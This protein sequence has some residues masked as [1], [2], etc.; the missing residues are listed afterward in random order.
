MKPDFPSCEVGKDILLLGRA[1]IGEPA[2]E[3][4]TRSIA[5]HTH[6]H[7]HGCY[8]L[9]TQE[10]PSIRPQSHSLCIDVSILL[11][12]L[13]VILFSSPISFPYFRREAVLRLVSKMGLH[14]HRD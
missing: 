4:A 13:L 7:A 11:Y 2:A 8:T 12:S 5:L 14:R 1:G 9:P 6:I 3:G 10:D